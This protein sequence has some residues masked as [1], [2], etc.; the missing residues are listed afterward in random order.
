MKISDLT[1]I[2]FEKASDVEPVVLAYLRGSDSALTTAVENKVSVNEFYKAYF[3]YFNVAP[4]SVRWLAAGSNR[5]KE[6]REIGYVTSEVTLTCDDM[7]AEHWIAVPT[8]NFDRQGGIAGTIGARIVDLQVQGTTLDRKS[9]EL[10][11]KLAGDTVMRFVSEKATMVYDDDY[12]L[13]IVN[14]NF[15]KHPQHDENVKFEILW[16]K[17]GRVV[18][19]PEELTVT[20]TLG[21]PVITTVNDKELNRDMDTA[22]S[23]GLTNSTDIPHANTYQPNKDIHRMKEGPIDFNRPVDPKLIAD[24]VGDISNRLRITDASVTEIMA[25]YEPVYKDIYHEFVKA[26][27]RTPAEYRLL[28]RGGYSQQATSIPGANDPLEFKVRVE[29]NRSGF[30]FEHTQNN[31]HPM[32]P[33]VVNGQYSFH[34]YIVVTSGTLKTPTQDDFL[35]SEHRDRFNDLVLKALSPYFHG[36]MDIAYAQH[37]P[38]PMGGRWTPGA[39][40]PKPFGSV[41]YQNLHRGGHYVPPGTISEGNEFMPMH[42]RAPRRTR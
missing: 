38:E 19:A 34:A 41:D 30:G 14:Y 33:L 15:E 35:K 31:A 24:M 6:L 26:T 17:K 13:E 1:E 42:A 11:P 2:R 4:T 36:R 20:L 10:E 18:S 29:P 28:Y 39:H 25:D 37:S 32:I 8:P 22:I 16:K 9:S 23:K 21:I 40:N 12:T 7:N 3:K 27:N 5:L